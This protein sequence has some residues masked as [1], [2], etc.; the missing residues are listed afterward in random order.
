MELVERVARAIGAAFV[1][2]TCGTYA[3]DA[4]AENWTDEAKAAIAAMQ[5]EP[6]GSEP[7]ADEDAL[8]AAWKAWDKHD[9]CDRAHFDAGWDAAV[10]HFK[11]TDARAE[12]ERLKS[13]LRDYLFAE[14]IDDAGE[15]AGELAACRQ[16]VHVVLELKR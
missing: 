4:R 10:A 3:I 9:Q 5:P 7:V 2:S 14:E 8:E 6:A 16:R 15:R 11:S 12:V 13:L 1:K